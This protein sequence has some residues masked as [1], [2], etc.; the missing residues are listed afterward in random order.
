VCAHAAGVRSGVAFA[1]AL[2]VL[3]GRERQDAL[4]VRQRHERDF[5]AGLELLD[6]DSV[7][8]RAEA[9]I[10]E[11]HAHRGV[12]LGGILRMSTPLPCARPS[13]LSTTG[14]PKRAAALRHCAASWTI[15]KS[16][17][18]MPWRPMNSL[19]KTLEP[20]SSAAPGAG[21]EDQSPR[22]RTRRRDRE[23]EAARGR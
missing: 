23:R 22:L 21:T 5:L 6:D 9:A 16:A 7:G 15:S 11:Q 20:S 19:A 10:L 4:A 3:A 1:D 8:A 2:V 14:K 13:A 12:E 18:G 17:V